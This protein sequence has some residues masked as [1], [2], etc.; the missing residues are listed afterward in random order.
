M[1][2][3]DQKLRTL[4]LMQILLDRT[5]DRHILNASELCRI[6][7]QKYD[8]STDRRTIYTEMEILEKFGLDIQQKKGKNPGY[9][10]GARDFEL[11][12]LKL[13]VDA[14]QSSKFITEKKSKELIQKLEKLCCRTDAAILSKYVFIVNRPKT[15]NE[16]VYYNV[17]YIHNAIY[18]N[19][20]ITFQYAEWTVMKELKLKKGGAFYVVSPWALTWDDENYYL[21]AYDAAAGIIKH[22]RVDKMQH[23]E[24]LDEERKGEESFRNFDLA[25]F[26]KKTF[27]M[28]GGVDTEVTLECRNEL[29]GVIIDRFG[30]DVWLVPQGKNHFTVR[31]LVSVSPQFF[32]WITGIGSGMKIAEPENV[33]QQYKDYMLDVMKNY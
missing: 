28:Y 16:T 30:H 33:K 3:F 2:S 27:G 14:V 7:E 17:D 23:T 11:P 19:K 29:A 4:R 6:L 24:I 13:L 22:Y 18:E 26:A 31:V 5:D 9:Y 15:E 10:I 8:I 21:V 25:A 20:V 1:A 12:E 32:G